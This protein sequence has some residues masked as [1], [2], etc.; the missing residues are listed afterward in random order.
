MISSTGIKN[1]LVAIR[2]ATANGRS[3][4]IFPAKKYSYASILA[5]LKT[6]GFIESFEQRGKLLTVGLKQSYSKSTL[7]NLSGFLMLDKLQ[8]ISRKDSMSGFRIARL[9]RVQGALQTSIFSTDQGIQ[10]SQDL[11]KKKIG[12][13]PLFQVK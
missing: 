2:L 6:K 12:G 11:L 13:I 9:E 1:I 4:V 10:T 7:Q 8:R 3:V 5:T